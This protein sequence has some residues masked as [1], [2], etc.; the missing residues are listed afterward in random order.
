MQKQDHTISYILKENI[1]DE[2]TLQKV[3][4]EQEASGQSLI[5][6]LKKNNLVD[7]EQFTK[8]IAAS[9]KI[10]FINLSPDMVDSMTAHMVTYEMANQHNMI[11]VKKE[12]NRLLVAMSAPL[13]LAVR[14][15]IEIRTA[16]KVVPLAATPDAIT[17]AIRYHFNVQ[18][19]TR[20]SVAS[21]RLKEDRYKDELDNTE[22]EDKSSR[23]TD[24][25]ITKLVSSIITAAIDA[26]ASDIHIEP[27][28]PDMRVRYRIDGILRDEINVPSSAQ[29]EMVS[30]IKILAEMDIS[31]RRLPQDGHIALEHNGHDYDLRVSSLPAVGGE[32]I[33]IRILDKSINRWLLD[34][35]VTS[36]DDNRKFRELVKNPYGMLLLTGPT[37][38]GKTTTLYS[39]LQLLNTPERNIVTVEDPV[40]YC[41]DN[42]TQ[43]GVKPVTGVTFA[44]TLRSVLRQD[45][46]IIL[47]GEIRD[48]E[49]AEIAISAA[50][51]GHLVLSTLHTNDAAGAI[52]RLINLGI[53]P[54]LVASVLLG[55]VAQRLI[56]TICPKCKQPYTPS[57]EELEQLF[58]SC[59]RGKSV[60][61][62]RG[63]GCDSCY[64]TGYRG[65]KAIYEILCVSHETHK[66]IVEASSDD[67]IKRQTIAEGMKTLRK[68]GVEEVLNGVTT[69]EELT[70][71]VDM[72]LE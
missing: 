34:D 7:E 66:M 9:N 70:R 55:T 44:S 8:I 56:R 17:Q 72:R 16:C 22:L 28:E 33:V 43:V 12:D 24:S 48:L 38:C 5:S 32:K 46:D 60:Q 10:E 62:Y 15:Q 63:Q 42:I 11:P 4:E 65:R 50:L 71:V 14:D 68:S 45:P 52:S 20:Q 51:T 3:L 47:V 29:Q 35:I 30:H 59:G 19:V 27:Q 58:A 36:P 57:S 1:L 21:M 31:E 23:V 41:L 18:N 40:E 61:L 2:E 26:R 53:Q 54:F 13:N 6:I 67:A 39:V 64:H 25:L 49:T 37:G 69:L